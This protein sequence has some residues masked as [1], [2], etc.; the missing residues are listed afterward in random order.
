MDIVDSIHALNREIQEIELSVQEKEK[1]DALLSS[2]I[3]EIHNE[4][5]KQDIAQLRVKH[6]IDSEL[7]EIR[8]KLYVLYDTKR[9]KTDEVK[10]LFR[11]VS[12]N[13]HLCPIC[14]EN[15][16]NTF[17]SQCGH[18]FCD[19]CIRNVR[20]MKCPMCRADYGPFDI[21]SLIFS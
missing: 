11:C 7:S 13:V 16:V 5:L 3:Q 2:V 12:E 10:S 15:S 17:V 4:S 6:C 20:Y 14:L 1:D 21:K 8:S 9:R 19:R 18:S